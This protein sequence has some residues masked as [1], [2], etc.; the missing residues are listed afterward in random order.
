MLSPIKMPYIHI[1]DVGEV[2]VIFSITLS[3]T[4]LHAMQDMELSLGPILSAS[5]PKMSLP[6]VLPT[7][8][9]IM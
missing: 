8:T 9:I 4:R 1:I 2:A 5:Q 6:V 7:A 3:A